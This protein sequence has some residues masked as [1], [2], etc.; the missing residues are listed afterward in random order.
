[1]Q[2]YTKLNKSGH[3]NR[4]MK[5]NQWTVR[6]LQQIGDVIGEDLTHLA[7]LEGK[8]DKN[9]NWKNKRECREK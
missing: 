9:G 2:V 5:T 4:A 8:M 1:M 6:A 3:L 7:N